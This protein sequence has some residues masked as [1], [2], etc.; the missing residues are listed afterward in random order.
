[1]YYCQESKHIY[2]R[3][4]AP[5]FGAQA[6]RREGILFPT[7]H[8]FLGNRFDPLSGV[9]CTVGGKRLRAGESTGRQTMTN[10]KATHDSGHRISRLRRVFDQARR[11]NRRL[12]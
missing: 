5:W 4:C 2:S 10:T 8:Q 6:I 1:M 7:L 11:R 9:C 3:D 12:P